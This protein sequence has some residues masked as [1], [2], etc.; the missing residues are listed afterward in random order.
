MRCSTILFLL[1]GLLGNLSGAELN[2][3]SGGKTA[4]AIVL[5]DDAIPAEETGAR[6]LADHLHKMTGAEFPVVAAQAYKGGPAIAVGFN[7][8]LPAA[9]AQKQFPDLGPEELVI[10]AEGDTLLL[11]GGRPRGSLYAVY[12][13]LEKLGVNWYTPGF[14]KIP[15]TPELSVQVK[16]ERYTSPFRSRT[17]VPGNG[18]TPEWCARNR[19]N[20]FLQWNNPG[21]AYGSGIRQGPDMHSF[22]RIFNP[23]NF[24]AHPEWAAMVDG[25][26]QTA[27]AN[28]SWG[29]CLSNAELRRH[30]VQRTLEWVRKNPGYT[31]VW[32][33]QN[34]GS[35][36][37]TCGDCTAF[38]KAHGGKPSS[39][40]VQLI[41]ELAEAMKQE[42]PD[43]RL[44][45]LA[46]SWSLEPP[47]NMKLSPSATVM[48][49]AAIPY[50]DT[51]GVSPGGEKFISDYRQWRKV[52]DNFEIYLYSYPTDSSWFPAPCLYSQARNI[53]WAADSGFQAVHQEVFGV[54][55]GDGGD[56]AELRAWLYAQLMWHP[57][58]DPNRLV[59]EF[60][61]GYYGKAA[62]AVLSA[63]RMTNR[64]VE[65]EG[66]IPPQKN[67]SMVVPGYVQ[68]KV[69]REAGAL[70]ERTWHS[71][72]DPELKKR[73]G[74]V[75]LP[76]L[77]AEFWLG[78][79]HYAAYDKHSG[80][81][82]IDI[83]DRARREK[84][85]TLIRQLMIENKVGALRLG[86]RLNPHTM[87]LAEM[88]RNYPA[89]ELKDAES[90]AV[91]VPGFYGKP[92]EFSRNSDGCNPLK[93][94]WGFKILEYPREGYWRDIINGSM[95]PGYSVA[96]KS[97]TRLELAGSL[98][99]STVRRTVELR[100]GA[101]CQNWTVTVQ[102]Q[103]DASI[104]VT[105]FLDLN[106]DNLGI[107]PKLHIALNN[108]AW[109]E[110]EFGRAGTMWYQ[111]GTLDIK[112]FS[113]RM[114]LASQDGRYGVLFEV[115]P[116]E[117]DKLDYLYDRYNFQPEGSG[118]ILELSFYSP[119]QGLEPGKSLSFNLSMRLLSAAEM[120]AV[121]SGN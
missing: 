103:K 1:L 109:R 39:L 46:Y 63:I 24:K 94:A 17:Q 120:K 61:R 87:R 113:G 58:A 22:W 11:G 20:S 42:F 107:Y 10:Q 95:L 52:A 7:P 55:T 105:P 15:A 47:E 86:V 6:E 91:I 44:K 90:R 64:A 119:T 112:E 37:C 78:I 21:T 96:G 30:L 108:G 23:A 27:T 92:V 100:N 32:I 68:P 38:Y 56:L 5:P 89:V 48:L 85:G 74:C 104:C 84:Y 40:I 26:R 8:R 80:M 102:K 65:T 81:W 28:H 83:P 69:N 29:L 73:V 45:T 110:F 9:L 98:P 115:P 34:D 93:P 41:N 54:G 116:R 66:W 79:N 35:P 31:D 118:R 111:A 4:Y 97:R 14:T 25:K 67:I 117:L 101:L 60:C 75:W 121:L 19:M 114:L 3:A 36:Y 70:L 71:T 18:V 33:G 49:C 82:G 53:R 99:D 62:D 76:Y 77:W 57:D 13:F 2:L 88:T 16:P 72:Q 106:P 51:L 59:E 43:K 50:W 12:E